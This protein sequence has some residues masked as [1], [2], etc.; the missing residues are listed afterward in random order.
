MSE[1]AADVNEGREGAHATVRSFVAVPLPEALRAELF[2]AAAV[3]WRGRCRR[4]E[5][6]AQGREPARHDQVPGARGGRRGSGRARPPRSTARSVTLPRFGIA[7]RGLG[8]FPSLRKAQR[9]LGRRRRIEP[10]VWPGSA[11]VIETLGAELGVG[12]E[13]SR[14]RFGRT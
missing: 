1:S 2:S 5:V 4:S 13:P 3:G 12:E 7:L 6:V 14:V 9:D 10:A 11:A 8:A